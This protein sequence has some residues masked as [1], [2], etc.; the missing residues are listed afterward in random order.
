MTYIDTQALETYLL[1][2]SLR[3]VSYSLKDAERSVEYHVRNVEYYS[4]QD[5][6]GPVGFKALAKM[7]PGITR[8][9]EA[10][11]RLRLAS[12]SSNRRENRE[13]A[14]AGL[15]KAEA[16]LAVLQNFKPGDLL[17]R[18]A[19]TLAEAKAFNQRLEAWD[20]LKAAQKA[21]EKAANTPLE[22]GDVRAEFKKRFKEAGLCYDLRPAPSHLTW[23]VR[24]TL[25]CMERDAK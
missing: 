9:Q 25:K 24:F 13:L 15:A 1:D 11:A 4:E 20:R 12:R 7:F 19:E 23:H 3:N 6:E 8:K 10:D 5:K 18:E 21:A 2:F 17:P 16:K 14:R 22:L